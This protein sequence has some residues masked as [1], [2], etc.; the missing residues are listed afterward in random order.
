MRKFD[1]EFRVALRDA[2][3]G[4]ESESGVEVVAT[5]LPRTGRFW[6]L[7]LLGGL[8]PALLVFTFLMFLEAEF[9][10]VLIYMETVGTFLIGMGVLWVFPPLQRWLIGKKRI[11]ARVELEARAL[12]QKAGIHET[13]ERIG[14]LIFMAWFERVAVVV[15]DRGA[16]E[17]IPPDE[18]ATIERQFSD[19][20]MEKDVAQAVLDRLHALQP[21]MKVYIP[22]S[23]HDL[24]ELPD[25][26]WLH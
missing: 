16:E 1:D 18:L 8:V 4:I 7:L 5:I 24:N 19:A 20:L 10:Y 17:L 13:K 25:E 21:L 23:V 2:V 15:A 26:L 22:R 3:R 6:G 14:V 9:W 12:F 11:R